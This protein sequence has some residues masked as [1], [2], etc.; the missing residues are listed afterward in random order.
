MT[1]MTPTNVGIHLSHLTV[2]RTVRHEDEEVEATREGVFAEVGAVVMHARQLLKI[3]QS[4]LTPLTHKQH[5]S[6]R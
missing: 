3:N 2:S 6:T 1:H 5:P 4:K